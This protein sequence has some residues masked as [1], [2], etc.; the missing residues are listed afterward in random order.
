MALLKS[1]ILYS[2]F[3][4]FGEK[5]CDPDFSAPSYATDIFFFNL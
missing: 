2:I 5:V 4:A 1:V 3:V